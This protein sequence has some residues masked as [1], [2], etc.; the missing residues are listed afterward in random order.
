VGD[1]AARAEPMRRRVLGAL[2]R[3]DAAPRERA[4]EVARADAQFGAHPIATR[5]HV[6]P[7]AFFLALAP[8]Q[9]WRP[10]RVRYPALHRW[11]GRALVAAGAAA[12]VPGLYFGLVIPLAG[13]GESVIIAL[14]GGIYITSLACG[15]A[16]I[17]GGRVDRHREWMIRAFAV[18]LGI[19]T[20]RVVAAILDIVVS[21]SGV[22]LASLFLASLWI[23]WGLTLASAEAWIR[24]TRR[25]YASDN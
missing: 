20:V 22:A 9:F 13:A 2:G 25:F 23:G 15:V 21:P 18:A 7:G 24:Y 6:L 19:S 11:S 1:L 3:A 5:G 12:T 8:L 14:A 16:A 4:M 17:R 10:L